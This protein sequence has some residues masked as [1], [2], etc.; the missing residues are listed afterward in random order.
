M[1]GS[2]EE[3]RG[4]CNWADDWKE[5]RR[6]KKRDRSSSVSLYFLPF[7]WISPIICSIASP[8]F[9]LATTIH[10][11]KLRSIL[12]DTLHPTWLDQSLSF[13]HTIRCFLISLL[14]SPFCLFF[15]TLLGRPLLSEASSSKPSTCHMVTVVLSSSCLFI[16]DACHLS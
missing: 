6:G 9:L 11:T 10:P 13:N 3:E 4:T 7:L 15:S 14:S 8:S 16:R 2:G 5:E 12:V 1:N